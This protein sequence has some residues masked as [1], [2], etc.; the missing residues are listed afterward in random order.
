LSI[1][2]E[3]LGNLPAPTSADE[4][5]GQLSSTLTQ[6]EDEF[7]GVVENPNPGLKPDGR[8][9]PPRADNI[10]RTPEGGINAKTF[11]NLIEID[12]D[13]ATRILSRRSGDVV[14]SREGGG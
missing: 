6:V 11:G 5:F 14:Y 10:T 12:P 1:F 3:R 2:Y 8:M 4:A 7:S 9:Y 13:G